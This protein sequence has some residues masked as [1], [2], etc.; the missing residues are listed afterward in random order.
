M[1]LSQNGG[2]LLSQQQKPKGLGKFAARFDLNWISFLFQF[3]IHT[4]NYSPGCILPIQ[5]KGL[6]FP[7]SHFLQ[8]RQRQ[9]PHVNKSPQ[10]TKE[11]LLLGM[12]GGFYSKYFLP[13]ISSNTLSNIFL[14]PHT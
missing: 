4:K 11:V 14:F 5:Q 10:H 13:P 8:L 1:F 2:Y 7:R 6:P 12:A 9:E 3:I